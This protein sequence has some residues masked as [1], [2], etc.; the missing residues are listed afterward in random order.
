MKDAK[1]D[2]D[3]LRALIAKSGRRNKDIAKL[4]GITPA[5][6]GNYRS[7]KTMP[8]FRTLVRLLDAMGMTTG[9]IVSAVRELFSVVEVEGNAD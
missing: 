4:A 5:T 7:G 2:S 6:L 9:E 8:D 3:W 1:F